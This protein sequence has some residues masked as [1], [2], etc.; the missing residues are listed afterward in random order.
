MSIHEL[1]SKG[2]IAGVVSLIN[3]NRNI[4]HKRGEVCMYVYIYIYMYVYIL[5]FDYINTNTNT[6]TT[7]QSK[8]SV[9]L[10]TFAFCLYKW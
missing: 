6:N 7:H 8:W 3:D 1:C 10:Y 9:Q 2:D 5:I 4:V